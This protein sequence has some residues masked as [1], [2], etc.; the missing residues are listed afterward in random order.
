MHFI[1]RHLKLQDVPSSKKL[2]WCFLAA[3]RL[4]RYLISADR[5]TKSRL[6][7]DM[8]F[9]GS[10]ITHQFH[11]RLHTGLKC[12]IF[13]IR[14]SEDIYDVI[15]CFHSCLYPQSVFLIYNNCLKYI[16]FSRRIF[17][18]WKIQSCNLQVIHIFTSLCNIFNLSCIGVII[19]ISLFTFCPLSACCLMTC[20]CLR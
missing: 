10:Y 12:F 5:F 8:C 9:T 7:V 16:W 19:N 15:S 6:H 17:Y 11:M 2:M 13:Y 1:D 3:G 14:A 18:H 20:W 4:V